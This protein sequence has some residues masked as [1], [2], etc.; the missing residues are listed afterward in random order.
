MLSTLTTQAAKKR[1]WEP[2]P[3]VRHLQRA[4][5]VKSGTH[6]LVDGVFGPKTKA[7]YARYEVQVG[8]NGDGVPGRHSVT[9]L[10]A[11]RF[12]VK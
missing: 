1:G 2:K 4:L 10:G 11:S 6:L 8:G 5:N 3:S 7:A 9:L 12:T